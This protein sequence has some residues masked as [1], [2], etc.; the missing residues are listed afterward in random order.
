VPN[1]PDPNTSGGS[2][3]FSLKSSSGINPASPSYQ[4]AQRRAASSRRAAVP[5][6]GRRRPG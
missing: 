4:A 1:F 2:I 5:D 6:P 3:T